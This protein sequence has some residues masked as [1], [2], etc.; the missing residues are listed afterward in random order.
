MLFVAMMVVMLFDIHLENNFWD[1]SIETPPP[2]VIRKALTI[3]DCL[4]NVFTLTG[5]QKRYG[6]GVIVEKNG[7]TLVLTSMM[8][9]MNDFESIGVEFGQKGNWTVRGE[10]IATSPKWGLAGVAAEPAWHV[11]YPISDA[12]NIPPH[13]ESTAM[14]VT[15][16][17]PVNVLE[18]L[19]DDWY[20][21]TGVDENYVG[22]P[23]INGED[24][25]G[26]VIGVN[27]INEEQAIVVGN[28]AIK[29]FVAQMMLIDAPPVLET[30]Q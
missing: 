2:P 25:T 21:I 1:I 4:V 18:Y 23:L 6:K 10:L 3:E 26:I 15:G 17:V 30:T 16:G 24:I 9:F 22:A 13:T 12:P 11:G 29:K 14:D 5:D 28:R 7:E 20:L 19:N 8:I 27:S